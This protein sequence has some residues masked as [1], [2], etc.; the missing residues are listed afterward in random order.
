MPCSST[1]SAAIPRLF[2]DNCRVGMWRRIV[3]IQKAQEQASKLRGDRSLERKLTE[4][5]K[6]HGTQ[7][8]TSPIDRID[9]NAA[10]AAEK[11]PEAAVEEVAEDEA[12]EE[13]QRAAVETD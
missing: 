13:G 6:H 8:P 4:P 3:K 9:A 1:S 7:P 5:P 10:E 11:G 2:M 12:E